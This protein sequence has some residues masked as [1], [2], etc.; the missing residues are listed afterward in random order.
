VLVLVLVLVLM[1]VLVLVLVPVPV[2]VLVI[3]RPI[4]PARWFRDTIK[5]HCH[6]SQHSADP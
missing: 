2:I 1:L 6:P 4:V 5:S 3:D